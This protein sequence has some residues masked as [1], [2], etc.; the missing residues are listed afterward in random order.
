MDDNEE[1]VMAIA[2]PLTDAGLPSIQA[3]FEALVT[4]FSDAQLASIPTG[5]SGL[6]AADEARSRRFGAAVAYF[7]DELAAVVFD[8]VSIGAPHVINAFDARLR[9]SVSA[10]VEAAQLIQRAKE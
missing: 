2:V 6:D 9:Y 1:G 10:R 3:L 8:E 7:A 4:L 5:R